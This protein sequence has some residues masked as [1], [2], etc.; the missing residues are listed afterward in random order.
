[1]DQR[2][3]LIEMLINQII[4]IWLSLF[5]N[6]LI[7]STFGEAKPVFEMPSIPVN[8]PAPLNKEERNNNNGLFSSFTSYLSSYAADEPPEP[9]GEELSDTI[10]TVNCIEACPF[11]EMFAN[12]MYGP[13]RSF[14]FQNRLMLE[15]G[16]PC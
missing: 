10:R 9:S 2:P 14:G 3:F 6:S 7:P 11:D 12:I 15:Q 1:M 13:C 16:A 5:V 4:R 8:T